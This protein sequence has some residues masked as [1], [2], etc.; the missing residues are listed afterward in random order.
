MK[1]YPQGEW[2]AYFVPQEGDIYSNFSAT[3]NISKNSK[4]NENNNNNNNN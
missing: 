4:E 1:N 3:T 2:F